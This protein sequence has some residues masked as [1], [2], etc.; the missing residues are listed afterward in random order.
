[1]KEVTFAFRK[2]E[3]DRI[4]S[5]KQV[6]VMCNECHGYPGDFF[7]L[8]D[9]KYVITS[10]WKWQLDKC[11]DLLYPMF[12]CETPKDA[13]LEWMKRVSIPNE[14]QSVWIHIFNSESNGGFFGHYPEVH[15]CAKENTE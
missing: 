10:I 6:A 15:E 9:A 11:I 4:T 3:Q 5:E 1:M 12:G 8:N 14:Y 7:Y 2:E 13:A